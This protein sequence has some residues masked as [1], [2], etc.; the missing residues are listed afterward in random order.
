MNPKRVFN[1]DE[2]AMELGVGTHKVLAPV[3]KKQVYTV[4]S[5]TR[6]HVTL[7]VT[8]N[9]AGNMVPPRV[10][11]AGKRN[12]A[13]IKL[14]LPQDGRSEVWQFSYT[15]NGWMNQN[16]MVSIIQ[17]LGDFIMSQKIPAP[18]LLFMD[19]AKCNISLEITQLKIQ[20]ILLHPNMTHLKQPLDLT[21]F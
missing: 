5:S 18:V 1:F 9:A 16:I 19:G 6:D 21:Y 4:S 12:L 14:N 10:V 15:D 17:D 11:F 8:V 2:T 20:P 3:S 13:S 7:G